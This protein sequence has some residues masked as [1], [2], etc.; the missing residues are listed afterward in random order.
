MPYVTAIVVLR[1][2]M[3]IESRRKNDLLACL[4]LGLSGCLMP[5]LTAIGLKVISTVVMVNEDE[6]VETI[7]LQL[8]GSRGPCTHHT[9][10]VQS[11]DASWWSIYYM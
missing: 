7:L 11:R 9:I 4:F 1:L 8:Y 10:H 3:M 2:V 5:C 6:K